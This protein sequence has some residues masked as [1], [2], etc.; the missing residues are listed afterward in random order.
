MNSRVLDW[1]LNTELESC[2]G[3]YPDDFDNSIK[4]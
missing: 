1:K 3:Y 2:L 4:P